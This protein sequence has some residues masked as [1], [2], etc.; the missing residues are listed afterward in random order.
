MK[1]PARWFRVHGWS[2]TLASKQNGRV[3]ALLA[4]VEVTF[5]SHPIRAEC[6]GIVSGLKF[7]GLLW[8]V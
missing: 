8:T 4:C 1:T 7:S 5:V 6:R 2:K 3:I